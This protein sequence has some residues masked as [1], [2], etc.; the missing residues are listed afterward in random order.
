MILDI[1]NSKRRLAIKDQKSTVNG[2][3]VTQ[4]THLNPFTPKTPETKVLI[5]LPDHKVDPRLPPPSY[6]IPEKTKNHALYPNQ[7]IQT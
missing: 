4:V 3:V 7:S 2:K 6:K 5:I 1:Y